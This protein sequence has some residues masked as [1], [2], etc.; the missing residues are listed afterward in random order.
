MRSAA[1]EDA[2]AIEEME[3]NKSRD[4]GI[5]AACLGMSCAFG[6]AIGATSGSDAASEYFAGYLLEQSLSVDNLFVFVLLFEYFQLIENFKPI[7]LV[8]AGILIFSSYKLISQGDSDE[9][10]DMADNAVVKFCS[11]LFD[12][13]DDYDGDN[14]FTVQ[15]G[16]KM[17]TPLL[18]VLAVVEISD[19]VFAVDS[20][21]A[22][23]GV[24]KDPFI[25]Y[26]SNLFAIL[27]LRQL[28]TLISTAVGELKY[29]QTA[30]ALV[31]GFIGSKMVVEYTGVE[32]PTELSL[33]VVVTLLSGGVAASLYLPDDSKD[34]A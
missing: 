7:L 5:V 9:E 18:L 16:V 23:F 6:A 30:V 29:L 3:S 20:I 25:V 17:A 11:K 33:A 8:F 12:V 21:P 26:T 4:L 34:E 15:N 32:I 2:D 13:S 31:L 24:T 19:V 22:V 27:S 28:Y 1:S 14:F 10:E